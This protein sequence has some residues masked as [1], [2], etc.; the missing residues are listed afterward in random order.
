M[1]AVLVYAAGYDDAS[2]Q[3][4]MLPM[5]LIVLWAMWKGKLSI[6]YGVGGT[7]M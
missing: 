5:V 6:T 1:Y 7:R 2:L 4:Y 3:R